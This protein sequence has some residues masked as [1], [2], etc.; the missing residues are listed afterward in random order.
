MVSQIWSVLEAT[1]KLK[2]INFFEF[3]RGIGV[4][5]FVKSAREYLAETIPNLPLDCPILPK[6]Y[7]TKHNKTLGE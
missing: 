4:L 2:K 6:F 1:H 3:S 7:E 5:P